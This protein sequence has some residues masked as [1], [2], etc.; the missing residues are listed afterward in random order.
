MAFPKTPAVKA[1]QQ[2]TVSGG[3]AGTQFPRVLLFPFLF[4][5]VMYHL[6]CF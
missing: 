2:I 4:V 6:S 1:P 3:I 5:S